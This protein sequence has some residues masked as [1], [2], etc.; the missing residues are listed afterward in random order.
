MDCPAC[1]RPRAGRRAR[2]C[3]ACGAALTRSRRTAPPGAGRAGRPRW[4]AVHVAGVLAVALAV[5][6]A[7]QLLAGDLTGPPDVPAES[8]E[9]QEVDLPATVE[10][11]EIPSPEGTGRTPGASEVRWVTAFEA[12]A[13]RVEIVADRRGGDG[14]VVVAVVDTRLVA[15]ETASG[16]VAWER[17]LPGERVEALEVADGRVMVALGPDGVVAVDARTGARVWEADAPAATAVL[18]G[19]LL[20]VSDDERVRAL[21]LED[22]AVRWARRGI[23]PVASGE[24]GEVLL[25]AGGTRVY[26][27]DAA[28]GTTRWVVGAEGELAR[29]DQT[30]TTGVVTDGRRLRLL[31]VADGTET[32]GVELGLVLDERVRGRPRVAPDG[33]VVLSVGDGL[34][35]FDRRLGARWRTRWDTQVALLDHHELA[36]ATLGG[37]SIRAVEPST[38]EDVVRVTP[39][40]WFTAAHLDGER[41]ALAVHTPTR[42]RLLLADLDGL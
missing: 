2:W 17:D 27:L 15:L 9:Q 10:P 7:W 6:V 20:V 13:S 40:G 14:A 1:G 24:V 22:G 4:R 36:V 39:S 31:D 25:V 12:P 30:A 34:V 37:V 5:L 8:V 33:G 28:T 16:E 23:G 35:G 42:G 29:P 38:G 21:S 41:L 26:G 19:G 11:P 32:A 3:G 18:A